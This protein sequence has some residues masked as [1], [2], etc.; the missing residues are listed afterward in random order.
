MW[1]E[2]DEARYYEML[3]VLPPAAQSGLG[4]LLGEPYDHNE[5]GL[6]RFAAFVEINGK[7]YEGSPM[8]RV[9]FSILKREDVR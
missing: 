8:T 7:F 5:R 2:I 1:K 3:G 6:P 9:A 4:F